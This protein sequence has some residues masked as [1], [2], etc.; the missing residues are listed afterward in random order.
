M[1]RAATIASS[2]EAKQD[3]GNINRTQS[4]TTLNEPLPQGTGSGSVPRCQV[5]ILG[6]AEAQTRFEAASKQSNDPPLSRVNILGS[7]EDN[8][9]LKE[10]R[11]LCTMVC[12][13][14]SDAT[15]PAGSQHTPLMAPSTE[16]YLDTSAQS[17]I[18]EPHTSS[19]QLTEP[20]TSSIIR[21]TI[22]QEVEIPQSNILTQTLVANE[23]AFTGVDV[24]HGK[25]ATIVSSIDARQGSGNITKSCPMIHL[26]QEVESLETELKQTKQTYGASFTKLI[27]KVKKL[28]Q[29]VKTSQA[30][31]RTKIIASDDEEALVAEDPSK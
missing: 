27:K 10:L 2:L 17:P 28:K 13:P 1:E 15:I 3:S 22:R 19:P 29:T 21:E 16:P 9:K 5:T 26:F 24:V 14:V 20:P 25:A 4:M 6:G 31:K 30:R 11:E 23:A 18:T 12:L 7:G 8:M